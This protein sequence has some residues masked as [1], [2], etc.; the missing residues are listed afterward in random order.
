MGVAE[1]VRLIVAESR[2]MAD[3]DLVARNYHVHIEVSTELMRLNRKIRKR[4]R[5]QDARR[6]GRF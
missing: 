3:S 2:R 4:Q 6:G 5:R 1:I